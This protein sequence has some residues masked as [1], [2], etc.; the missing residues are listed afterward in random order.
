MVCRSH[1]TE[2]K[3]IDINGK[4]TIISCEGNFGNFISNGKRFKNI[5]AIDLEYFFVY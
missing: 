5:Q 1:G 4:L 2:D 3:S